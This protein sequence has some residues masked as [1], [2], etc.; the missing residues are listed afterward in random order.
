MKL[1]NKNKIIVSALALAI[2][3]SLVGSISGTVAWYQYSTRANVSYIGQASGISSNL[4]MRF[5]SEA[6]DDTAWR[7]RITWQ[8]MNSQLASDMK[9]VPMT[10]GGIKKDAALPM[11]NGATPAPLGYVQP[12][13]GVSDMTKWGKATNKNYV[14]FKLQLRNIKRGTQAAENNEENVYISKLVIQPDEGNTAAGKYDLSDAV[15]VHVSSKYGETTGNKLISK[16]GQDVLTK[17][18]LD[19]D[20]DGKNDQAYPDNDEFGFKHTDAQL[21]DVIYGDDGD[22]ST[23][24]I[25]TSY[26]NAT[27]PVQG[28]K[29]TQP[30]LDAAAVA[31]GKTI[32]DVKIEGTTFTQEEI[33]AAQEGDDAYGKTTADWKV[34]PVYFTQEEIDLA[35]TAHNKTVDDWKVAPIDPALVYAE[36]NDNKLYNT[37]AKDN[38]ALAESKLI[39]KTVAG[40]ASYLEVTITIW[41]EGWQ[42]LDN[43]TAIWDAVKYIGSKFNVGIQFAV[44]DKLS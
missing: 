1:L 24:E 29:W 4:Q 20:A 34:E 6:D 26:A 21:V 43:G 40:T 32:A 37:S 18:A 39:G 14:Q 19:I 15:R 3:T 28:V 44:Q 5:A 35:N 10:F 41:I 31:Y 12:L 22:N 33:D 8:E 42:K 2:G 23:D 11:D 27:D 30:E 17:G 16:Q 13:V 25:Q 38:S 36:V 7:T 9:L